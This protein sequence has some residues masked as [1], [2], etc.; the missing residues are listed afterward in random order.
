MRIGVLKEIK[1]NERRVAIT[2][3]IVPKIKNL[4]Y[5]VYVE[6][7][8]G[9]ESSLFDREYIEYGAKICSRDEVYKCDLLVKIN[10]P[11][12]D[13]ASQLSNS[14]TLISFFSPALNSE[15]LE[16]CKKDKII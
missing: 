2:P 14:Q 10:K 16:L 8:S 5:E 15:L 11:T 12:S 1:D 13:E 3:N 7:D 6:K 4:G 9:S